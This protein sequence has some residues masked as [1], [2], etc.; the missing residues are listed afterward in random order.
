MPIDQTPREPL[1]YS[2]VDLV[3]IYGKALW[4]ELPHGA[5]NDLDRSAIQPDPLD[6][7][8]DKALAPT[9]LLV[10][11]PLLAA[12]SSPGTGSKASH[13]V[14]DPKSALQSA[15]PE[16]LTDFGKSSDLHFNLFSVFQPR[17]RCRG[18]IPT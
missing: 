6:G 7:P 3:I 10:A 14:S 4:R 18:P 5:S 12:S 11:L 15:E 13:H 1:S 2:P 8:P 17:S 9:L 16:S